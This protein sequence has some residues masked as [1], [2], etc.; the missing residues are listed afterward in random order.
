M[1][2]EERN[3]TTNIM[4]FGVLLLAALFTSAVAAK[5]P[6]SVELEKKAEVE[7][8]L[9]K[10]GLSGKGLCGDDV[11]YFGHCY[12]FVSDE[13]TWADAEL[14]CQ[15]LGPKS[16]LASVHWEKQNKLIGNMITEAKGQLVNTWI[17]LSDIYKEGTF[18]WSDGSSNDFTFWRLQQPDDFKSVEDCVHTA[19]S[20]TWNDLP[21]SVQLPSIC[22]YKLPC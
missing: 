21:C 17:G 12:K 19:Q 14:Y 18:L 6:P 20:G 5:P 8:D 15:S 3:F 1:R 11:Y 4:L 2:F 16:H 10:R 22:S 9:G 13:M 7:Q